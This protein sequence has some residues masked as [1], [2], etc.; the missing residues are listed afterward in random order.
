MDSMGKILSGIIPE[1]CP[2]CGKAV[3]V[4]L[5]GGRWQLRCLGCDWKGSTFD[6]RQNAIAMHNH[7]CRA[8]RG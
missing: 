3:K 8:A 5:V 2:E 7:L 1:P 4:Y 6:T